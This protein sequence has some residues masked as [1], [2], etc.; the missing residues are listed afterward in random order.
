MLSACR[1]RPLL[2][3]FGLRQRTRPRNDTGPIRAGRRQHPMISLCPQRRV[4]DPTPAAPRADPVV[5]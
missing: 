1:G 2:T 5:D 4:H 3:A